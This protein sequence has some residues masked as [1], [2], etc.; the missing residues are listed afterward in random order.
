MEQEKEGAGASQIEIVEYKP[1]HR[2]RFKEINEQWIT[3]LY[4][5]EEEDIKT[6]EDPE[7]YV[8][9]GG[10][11]IY[12]ALYK[13]YPV[14]TCAYL[15]MGDDVYEMI[16][17]AVDEK[18]RGL[19]IGKSIGEESV[20][21]IKELGAKRIILF[22]NTTGSA[23]AIDMYRKLGFKEVPLGNSEFI[24]ADIKMELVFG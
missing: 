18:F 5:M 20:Q 1:E 23:T 16:K 17:M 9:K 4:V 10:G 22:S 24:R 11:K 8:L 2:L 15:N 19:K 6:V 21:R 12:I 7:G 14:G 3:R 13:G